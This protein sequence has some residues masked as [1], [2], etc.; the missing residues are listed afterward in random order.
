LIFG[1]TS[2][3]IHRGDASL[4]HGVGRIGRTKR[5]RC[6]ADTEIRLEASATRVNGVAQ[7]VIVVS[8]SDGAR[9][10]FGALMK[11]ESKRWLAA[12]LRQQAHGTGPRARRF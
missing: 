6:D 4:F 1:K 12:F 7:E 2:V 5:F 3:S 9:V 8:S 11:D 10:E